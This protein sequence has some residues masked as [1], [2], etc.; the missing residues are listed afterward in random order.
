MK[1]QIKMEIID[2][3]VVVYMNDTVLFVL[4]ATNKSVDI[5]MLYNALNITKDD[6]LENMIVSIDNDNK[7]TLENVYSNAKLFLDDLINKINQV[8][9]NFDQEKE[10]DLLIQQ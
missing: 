5:H 8:I 6:Y 3:K 2:D 1:K 10:I 7:S 4:T 9:S